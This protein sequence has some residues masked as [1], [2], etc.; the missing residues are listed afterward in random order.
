MYHGKYEA[1]RK[2]T[3][4]GAAVSRKAAPKTKKKKTLGTKIFYT[5][6]FLMIVVACLGIWYGHG[7]LTEFLVAFEAS[8]P[9][10]K[11]QQVFDQ[12]FADPDWAQVYQ[13]LDAEATAEI[14]QEDF[15][16]YM[17]NTVAGRELTYTKTSA[18]LSGGRKY[19]LRLDGENLG[20][21]TLMNSVTGELEIP[22]WRLD[23]VEI[24]VSVKEYVTVVTDYSNTVTVNGAT[25][26]EAQV[27]HKTETVAE[28]Y[29][30]D[31]VNGPRTVTYFVKDLLNAPV[32]TVTDPNGN[33]VEMRYDA[34]SR[35]YTQPES[36]ATLEIPKD[37]RNFVV[38]ATKTYFRYM[39]AA[40]TK[41]QL[42][43]YF[44]KNSDTYKT[45][46]KSDDRWLQS[47]KTY[48]YGE[49]TITD[50]VRY[51]DDLFSV[52][53]AMDLLVTRNNNTVKTF[54]MD[55]TYF[56]QTKGKSWIVAE[57]TNVDVTKV[58][59]QV[60]LTFQ[61]NG[62]VLSSAMYD[63]ETAVLETPT[64]SAPEGK[65]FSGWFI[66][67]EDEKGNTTYTRVFQ[68]DEKGKVMLPTGYI[69]EPMELHAL[70]EETK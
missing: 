35:T 37:A 69:L 44:D 4:P 36:T 6:Y 38:E 26:G 45:I 17:E 25:L 34:E 65:T 19:I 14:T 1:G 66:Q 7:L 30:P 67:S 8:Q 41:T 15:A 58:L 18:G 63:I 52:R 12:Y 22:D 64:V 29:L 46:I 9:D 57:M 48:N 24:F 21:F 61:Q 23:A 13:L 39:V 40:A 59:T 27:I 53:I 10:T 16:A 55:S 47:Y 11:C 68:P 3:Q 56:I 42:Q 43:D 60:R 62:Q 49:P 28:E 32:V 5:L 31:G 20:T 51:S 50:Y 70:F 33:P 54:S 2:Q